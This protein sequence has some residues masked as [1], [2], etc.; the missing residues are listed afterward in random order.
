MRVGSLLL[1][2]HPK[3]A[4]ETVGNVDDGEA[5]LNVSMRVLVLLGERRD[6]LMVREE[7]EVGDLEGWSRSAIGGVAW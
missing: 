7:C 1:L 6:E 2:D 4:R 5:L 3:R